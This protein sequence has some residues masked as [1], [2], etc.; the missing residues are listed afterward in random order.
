MEDQSIRCAHHLDIIYS[1]YI[2]LYEL[3]SHAPGNPNPLATQLPGAHTNGLI[4]KT[5][6][7]A[8]K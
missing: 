8:I 1:K 3:L 5:F 4:G 2:T 7:V 6:G